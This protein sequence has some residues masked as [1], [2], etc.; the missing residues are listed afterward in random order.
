MSIANSDPVT[1][2]GFH[3]AQTPVVGLSP[4]QPVIRIQGIAKRYQIADSVVHALRGADLDVFAGELIAIM[5]PSG[6]GK[7]T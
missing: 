3:P 7:S 6:S 5:G 2:A 4:R 1:R